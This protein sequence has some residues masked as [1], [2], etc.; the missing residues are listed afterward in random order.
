VQEAGSANIIG[1][2]RGRQGSIAVDLSAVLQ[3]GDQYEV[4]NV[5]GLF[6]VPG[7]SGTG[8]GDPIVIP[9]AGIAPPVLVGL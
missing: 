3:L 1:C 2:N 6:G 8:Q 4:R 5:Q 9:L 7:A